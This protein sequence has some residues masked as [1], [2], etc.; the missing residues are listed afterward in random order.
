VPSVPL[1][2]QSDGLYR[3]WSSLVGATE[4]FRAVDDSSG[5][6]HDGS[7]SYFVLPR[8]VAP[9]GMVSFPLFAS[10][11]GLT[12]TAIAINIVA[13]RGGASH[14]RIQVGFLR[15]AASGFDPTLIDAPASW[16][17]FA[18]NFTT[19]PL[20]GLAWSAADLPGLEVLLQSEAFTLGS[21]QVTL[22]SGT[23]FYLEPHGFLGPAG[24]KNYSLGR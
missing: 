8:L 21:N 12:P 1:S 3:G 22:V 20:T 14:P 19:N 24:P 5:T 7:A 2:P 18:Y 23:L 13:Q 17:L 15:G 4:G 16:T 11:A 6:A 10:V 9:A